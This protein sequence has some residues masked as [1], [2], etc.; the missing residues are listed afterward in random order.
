[1]I[2]IS[3]SKNIDYL[4]S[5]GLCSAWLIKKMKSCG[6]NTISD[7]K[8]A[9][10][11]EGK[12]TIVLMLQIS[13]SVYYKLKGIFG[14]F[15]I[16]DD[17]VA[18]ETGDLQESY[19][20]N[21][22][23]VI[24]REIASIRL[25]N[26]LSS[27]NVHTLE[28]LI[29]YIQDYGMT[30]LFELRNF[31]KTSYGEV[32][33]ILAMNGFSNDRVYTYRAQSKED[34]VNIS[35]DN[36]PLDTDDFIYLPN[37]Q[38]IHLGNYCPYVK[39]LAS[40]NINT[41][42]DL[43]LFCEK[44]GLVDL[45]RV[46][47]FK[48]E[49]IQKIMN[50]LK[51]MQNRSLWNE[52]PRMLE[53]NGQINWICVSRRHSTLFDNVKDTQML[54]VVGFIQQSYQ[55]LLKSLSTRAQNVLLAEMP[56]FGDF[57]AY[58]SLYNDNYKFFKNCGEK[59]WDEIELFSYRFCKQLNALIG[60]NASNIEI[61]LN[62]VGFKCSD[63][64]ERSFIANFYE[65]SGH[66]PMFYMLTSHIT[67][68]DCRFEK[69]YRSIYG[70][71][72]NPTDINIIAED[73]NLSNAR[74]RQIISKTDGIGTAEL[75]DIS[76]YSP[77][78][79][80][81]RLY[82][83]KG[84]G[85]YMQVIRNENLPDL[86]FYAFGYLVNLI[87]PV[88]HYQVRDNHYFFT[89]ELLDCFDVKSALNDIESTLTKR[90]SKMVHIPITA[91]MNS[92]WWRVPGFDSNIVTRILK[93]II[94]DNYDVDIDENDNVILSQ[95][96]IDISNELYE[97]I[98]ANEAPLSIDDIFERF[99][100]KYP[101]HKYNTPSQIRSYLLKDG[102]ICSMGKTSCY[103]LTK[104]NLFT[105]TI[106]DLISVTLLNSEVPLTAEEIY[107]RI[108]TTY[109]TNPKS[110]RSIVV[111]DNSG[112][113]VF[114]KDGYI[115]IASKSYS[116][117]F[118]NIRLKSISSRKAFYESLNEF[119]QYLITHHHMPSIRGSEEEQ[120]LYRWYSNVIYK[121]LSITEEREQDFKAMVER[122]SKYMVNGVEY[123]FYRK[124]DDYKVFID[125]NMELPSIKTNA[126]LYNWFHKNYKGYTKF[127]DRRKGY[128]ED[129][130]S[131][132]ESYGFVIHN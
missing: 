27:I 35:F 26:V 9:L 25:I 98:K 87:M 33:S 58:L 128:F 49:C 37:I 86:S 104:W 130:I 76:K 129:L 30:S 14:R 24:I 107:S 90:V 127:E 57:V 3:G 1:M 70:I 131:Y 89:Q 72:C 22:S 32:I 132:I 18:E 106:K 8:Y 20:P 109:D 45:Y 10:S 100:A 119:E 51:I 123:A 41:T 64:Q 44:T 78:D 31:G 116:T 60:D 54:D 103:A 105:G 94:S 19:I 34:A 46:E 73:Y 17:M 85:L 28:D 56:Y 62:Q 71:I 2:Q 115:G 125:E 118:E 122:N 112:K 39:E 36:I 97:I 55:S 11:T 120:Y 124:C 96:C 15:Q 99:K 91:F 93:E 113:F 38:L 121:C 95:N 43:Y 88:K 13:S 79:L 68:S 52:L 50:L 63:E 102:R 40:K 67:S 114:F 65:V 16:V 74:V 111:G 6:I 82:I 5:K 4:Y 108:C 80:L 21:P 7:L 48:M 12:S 84:E 83:S 47:G 53:S 81:S 77:Y 66:L 42:S 23:N 101:T 59:T 69:L 29:L 117:E 75:T 110:I 61:I 92:N 126:T